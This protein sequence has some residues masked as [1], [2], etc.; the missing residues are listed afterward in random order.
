MVPNLRLFYGNFEVGTIHNA[1]QNDGTCHGTIDLDWGGDTKAQE[2]GLGRQI[3]DFIRFTEDWNERVHRDEPADASE[4][5]P[6]SDL[7]KSRQWSTRDEKGKV[8]QI[9]DAPV[10]FTGGEVSWQID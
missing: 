9:I 10:F 8:N 4:F 6:Y 2:A 5:D 3:A 7:L 1:F